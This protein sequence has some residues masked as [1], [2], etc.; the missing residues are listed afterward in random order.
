MN[1]SAVGTRPTLGGFFGYFRLVWRADFEPVCENGKPKLFDS[2]EAAEAAAFAAMR[3]IEEPVMYA[4]RS[5]I[6]SDAR[7]KAE[8]VFRRG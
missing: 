8:A 3:N 4:D 2:R 1:R 6:S 7:R 5:G